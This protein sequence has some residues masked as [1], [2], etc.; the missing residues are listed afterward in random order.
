MLYYSNMGVVLH[1]WLYC[2]SMCHSS[3][4]AAIVGPAC[5]LGKTVGRVHPACFLT[6]TVGRVHS[7]CFLTKTGICA[8]R[9]F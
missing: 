2:S 9:V 5:F 1:R 8:L 7:A 3:V 4:Y 6:K